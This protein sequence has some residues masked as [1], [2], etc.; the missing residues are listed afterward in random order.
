VRAD[1]VRF[2]VRD[3]L[4][5]ATNADDS[6]DRTL[7]ALSPAVGLVWR[8]TPLASI[9]TTLSTSFE[10]PTTTEL[11]N[12]PDGSAGFNPELEPQRAV[13]MELG[14]KGLLA[15]TPLR[16]EAA[17]FRT[18]ARDELVP[19]DIPGGQ[20]RR[21][22]RNAGLTR[23]SGAELGVGADAGPLSIDAAYTWSHFRYVTYAVGAT[24][25]AGNRIPGVP[26]HVLALAAALRLGGVTLSST[27]DLASAM[28]VDDANSERAPGRRIL[29][30][31]LSNEVRVSGVRLSPLVAVQ[32]LTDARSVGSVSV[33]ASGGRFYEPAPGRTL[34]VRLAV[35][36]DRGD[37]P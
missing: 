2:Q 7:H 29:G 32:N 25:Y 17:L 9:Y 16:W 1:A 19:F 26:E 35:A 12:K 21:Y 33:N 22:F 23:R 24:S 5:S 13:S 36:R 15:A 20:G 27:A 18:N 8:A 14:A 37:T 11:G 34:L 28:D 31:A 10:T 4:V 30:V 6:G 3:R